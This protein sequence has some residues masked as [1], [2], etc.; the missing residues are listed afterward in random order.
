MLCIKNSGS[1]QSHRA[2][3]ASDRPIQSPL[4]VPTSRTDSDIFSTSGWLY[5]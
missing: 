2:R 3:S 4:R 1:D 5:S